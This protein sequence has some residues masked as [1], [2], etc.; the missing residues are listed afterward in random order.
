MNMKA[1]HAI[2]TRLLFAI[3]LFLAA[4]AGRAIA[5]ERDADEGKGGA[6]SVMAVKRDGLELV[7]KGS[8]GGIYPVSIAY[9]DGL[10]YV[11]NLGGAPTLDDSPGIPTMTGF[12]LD[13]DGK[14]DPIPG[15]TR[16]IGPFGSGPAD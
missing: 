7:S 11:I 3:C 2:K 8:S 9:H 16:I 10:V 12:R 14:L 15:S 5:E 6:V 4:Q 1:S 13:E